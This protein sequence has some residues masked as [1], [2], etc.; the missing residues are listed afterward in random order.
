MLALLSLNVVHAQRRM[1]LS[2]CVN[3]GI[4]R[5][6]TLSQHR[7]DVWKSQLAIKET[8]ANLLPQLN[9]F[10]N[11]NDNFEPATSLTYSPAHDIYNESK[12]LQ[13]NASAGI[14]LSMPV[15]NAMLYTQQGVMKLLSE[16]ETL[17]YD[18]ACE[19]LTVQIARLYYQGQVCMRQIELIDENLT[20]MNALHEIAKAYYDNQMSLEIDMQRVNLN[21]ESLRVQHDNA[22]NQLQNTLAMLRYVIA[23]SEEISLVP[24]KEDAGK[25]D[26]PSAGLSTSLPETQLLEERIKVSEQQQKLIRQGYL[27]SVSLTGTLSGSAYAPKPGDWFKDTEF[28]KIWGMYGVGLQVQVPIWD[29]FRKKYKLKQARIEGDNA[30]QTLEDT[31]AQLQTSYLNAQRDFLNS[32]RTLKRQL[33]NKKLAESVYDVTA[34]RYKEGLSSMTDVLQDEMRISEAQSALLTAYYNLKVAD[35]SLLKLTGNLDS[36]SK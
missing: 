36:L 34:T 9:G 25:I 10:V 17:K 5:N 31:Q 11:L 7:G 16:I 26:A 20:R 14:K 1:T 35:L 28:N 32:Q 24:I 12:Q 6:L 18:K 30:R 33:D 23:E 21:I 3:A 22:Q 8:R 29:S 27:P 13:Y 19:D 4:E 15:Y 2:E